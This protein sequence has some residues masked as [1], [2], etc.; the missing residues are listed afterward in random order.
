MV[1][2][3]VGP[4]AQ[5][6]GWEPTSDE[7]DLD[8]SSARPRLGAL[9]RRPVRTPR[10]S[11]GPKLAVRWMED[12][13]ST[14][15]DV[16]QTALFTLAA[17]GDKTTT[18]DRFFACL[19]GSQ[20]APDRAA[21]APGD[22]VLRLRARRSI[23]LLRRSRTALFATRT[24]LGR[25]PSHGGRR[26]VPTLWQQLRKT[27]RDHFEDA[28][29]D[30]AQD[31]RGHPRTVPTRGRQGRRRPSWPKPRCP[32]GEG[33]RRRTSRSYVPIVTA[34]R[35]RESDPRCAA[36]STAADLRPLP[37]KE[38]EAPDY[39]GPRCGSIGSTT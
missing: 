2:D 17:H 10:R 32:R 14:D 28:A 12:P 31:D 38:D 30:P 1:A 16:G 35:A 7:S 4:L 19:Q 37:P 29:A 22:H 27:G 23:A 36:T 13:K 39:R 20:D 25:C 6:T 9:G 26:A 8:R 24:G 18:L 3:L 34:A 5:R 33:D 11:N 21:T 15:P